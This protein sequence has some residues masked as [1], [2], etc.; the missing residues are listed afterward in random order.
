MLVPYP[1][2]RGD[3]GIIKLKREDIADVTGL[4]ALFCK[5]GRMEAP[6]EMASGGVEHGSAVPRE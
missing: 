2:G 4:S 1:C 5:G 6:V 3:P